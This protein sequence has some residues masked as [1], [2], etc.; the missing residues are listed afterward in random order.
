MT[1]HDRSYS[2]DL[3]HFVTGPQAFDDAELRLRQGSELTDVAKLATKIDL[4]KGTVQTTIPKVYILDSAD[5]MPLKGDAITR[6][7]VASDRTADIGIDPI[8]L[9]TGVI[10]RM[11]DSGDGASY[12]LQ[13]GDVAIGPLRLVAPERVRV[14]NGGATTFVYRVDLRN[15][16]DA[17]DDARI[18]VTELPNDWNATY[19]EAIHVP[20]KANLTFT[21]LA[22]VPFAH[23]HGGFDAFN[24]IARS[25]RDA[26]ALATLRL[27]VLHT[28]IPQ[29]AGHHSDLY[30][31]GRAANAAPLDAEF[32]YALMWMSTEGAHES[33]APEIPAN[34]CPEQ[35]VHIWRFPLDPTLRIGI[36][37]D[38]SRLGTLSGSLVPYAKGTG[39]IGAKLYL[40]DEGEG[41]PARNGRVEF[42]KSKALPLADSPPAPLSLDLATAVPFK[43]AITPRADADYVPFTPHKNLWLELTFKADQPDVVC[44]GIHGMTPVLTPKEFKLTLP[45][46]EYEDRLDG[47][48]EAASV[49]DLK[50][51]GPSEKTGR[52]GALMTYVFALTNAGLTPDEVALEL[53]GNDAKLGEIVPGGTIPLAPKETKRIVVGVTIPKD[54]SDETS[55]DVLLYAHSKTDPSKSAVGRTKT[56]A[57]H[58]AGAADDESALLQAAKADAAKDTPALAV[59]ALLAGAVGAALASRR[60]TG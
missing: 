34:D 23:K 55:Y 22:S 38:L 33:D 54:A 49:L 2:A 10:D 52:P 9:A 51:E 24:V 7:H 53:A 36:D 27:G 15:D 19:P 56:T 13:K 1:W 57:D 37:F 20:A 58:G 32:N 21:V 40:V 41:S 11:P 43:L 4:E 8:S 17:D 14:S 25:A 45:L 39:S 48:A 26:D 42:D 16:G 29:P 50:I 12:T 59:G 3:Y 35:G 28:P 18:S 6:V 44:S 47:I 31:H 5:R 60:R 30:I 46:N